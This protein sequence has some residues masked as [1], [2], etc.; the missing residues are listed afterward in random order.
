MCH[1]TDTRL[2]GHVTV[3]VP[4]PDVTLQW[5]LRDAGCVASTRTVLANM[6]RV[7]GVP[8]T[9]GD[10]PF[11]CRTP[12]AAGGGPE[13]RRIPRRGRAHCAE[14]HPI[15][16]LR[17]RPIRIMSPFFRPLFK[18]KPGGPAPPEPAGLAFYLYR[19]IEC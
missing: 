18:P 11:R 10:R 6:E 1:W 19:M 16:V 15:V 9:V 14:H 8:L 3:C 5:L 13:C 17:L 4:G 12:L 7:Q 2:Q